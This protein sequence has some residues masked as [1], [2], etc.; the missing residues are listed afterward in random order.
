MSKNPTEQAAMSGLRRAKMDQALKAQGI[1]RRI[2]LLEEYPKIVCLCGS[3]RFSKAFQDAN[4]EETLK[5]NI[6]LSIGCDL[7][8]DNELW[9]DK[10]PEEIITLKHELDRLH[11][12]KIE[13]AD[14][15]VILNVEGY[16]GSSTR[17]ELDYALFH[18]KTVRYLEEPV[19]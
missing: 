17:A 10:S 1:R 18:G 4:L 16:I 19:L 3:T 2:T 14:E 8:S 7:S 13:L 15:V 5:G 11:L 9:A 6:V 12:R